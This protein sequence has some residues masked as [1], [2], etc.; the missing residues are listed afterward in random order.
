MIQETT[1]KLTAKDRKLANFFHWTPWIA[2]PLIALPFPLVFFFLFLTSAATDTAAVYL[3]LAGVG[4]ALGAFAGGLVLILLFIYRARWLRRLRDKLAAD[5]ITA[6]EVAWF[7]QELST[8]ER[9]T[10]VETSKHSLL[11]EDAYRETLAS[12]LTA[13]RIIA[14]TDKEL[15]KIRSRIN[16]ARTLAGADTKTLLIDLESDQQQLQSLKTEANA[17]LADTRARLQTIEAAASRSLNQAET[18]AMLRRLSATQ[19][20]L[21]LVIEMDQLE[22]KTLQ[23][24]ERDLME[25]ESS[26]GTPGGPGLSRH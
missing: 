12:R 16:R 23:E 9:K 7:T 21:P 8:A 25:R 17:R 6:S 15:V 13:S 11:L 1:G 3:L 24:A 10:L 2:F 22:R 18:Q 5:G 26:L 14:T 20:H 4:L 19:D